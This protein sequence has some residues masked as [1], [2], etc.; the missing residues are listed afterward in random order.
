MNSC[1]PGA[2]FFTLTYFSG[3]NYLCFCFTSGYQVTQLSSTDNACYTKDGYQMGLMTSNVY[4]PPNSE[5]VYQLPIQI[6]S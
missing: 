3:G 2:A 1:D 5:A 4:A 6:S